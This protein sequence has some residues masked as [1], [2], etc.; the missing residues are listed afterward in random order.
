[1]EIAETKNIYIA[2][3]IEVIQLDNEISLAMESNAD[4][5]TEPDGPGW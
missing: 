4:P 5:E 2:P 1:M 3:E